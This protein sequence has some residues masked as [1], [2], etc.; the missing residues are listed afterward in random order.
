MTDDQTVI[1]IKEA[2]LNA[3][4]DEAEAERVARSS[5]ANADAV[6]R[7]TAIEKQLTEMVEAYDRLKRWA[8][9]LAG[10]LASNFGIDVMEGLGFILGG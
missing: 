8:I 1:L 10:L 9:G 4:L 6:R 2:M 5:Q 7:F 3:G